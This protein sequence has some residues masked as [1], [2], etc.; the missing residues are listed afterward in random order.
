MKFRVAKKPEGQLHGSI[1]NELGDFLK[2]MRERDDE[3]A[4][5]NASDEDT[6]AF[7]KAQLPKLSVFAEEWVHFVGDK[8]KMFK[9]NIPDGKSRTYTLV[10]MIGLQWSPQQLLDKTVIDLQEIGME[11]DYKK[12]QELETERFLAILGAYNNLDASGIKQVINLMLTEAA[13]LM[14]ADKQ[15]HYSTL[16]WGPD[17]IPFFDVWRGYVKHAP[18]LNRGKNDFQL[19]EDGHPLGIQ[20]GG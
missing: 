9:D 10:L 16:M 6:P 3:L 20:T 19:A 7:T 13:N 5:I 12:V 11:L 15:H 8:K 14:V 18:W 4:I 17:V 2:V 1:I